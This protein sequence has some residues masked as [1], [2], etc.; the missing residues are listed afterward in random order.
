MHDE[1]VTNAEPAPTTVQDRLTAAGL[2]RPDYGAR[3]RRASAV[4]GEPVTDR[5]APAPAGTP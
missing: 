5:D 2:S 4:D 1:V 3:D